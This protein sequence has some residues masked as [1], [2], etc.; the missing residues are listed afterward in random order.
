MT[1]DK[2]LSI[3]TRLLLSGK[4]REAVRFITERQESGGVMLPTEDAI[5]PTG[6]TVLEVLQLKH[7]EQAEPHIDA[8]VE[9][10]ELPAILEVTITEEH[11]RKTAHKLSG[12]A[13]PSGADSTL[14]QSMLLKYGNH[15][16]ELCE[17]MAMLTERQANNILEWEEVHAQKAKREL[18]LRKLPV[19]IR[20]IG[21]GELMDRCADKTMLYVT[22]DD[23]KITCNSDQLCSG[24]KSGMEGTIHATRE[25]FQANMMTDLVYF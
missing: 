22:E 5:K 11:I 1:D 25:L 18:A 23:V 9:C 13:G 24:I 2:A 20:P 14:W 7:P 8:F 16:K 10:E 21:V 15:S 12:S 19:G 17:A 4:I 6:K 3:F